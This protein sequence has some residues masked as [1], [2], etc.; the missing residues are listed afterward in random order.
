MMQQ[1]Y[2]VSQPQTPRAVS[3]G[4]SGVGQ[5]FWRA[6]VSQ[7]HPRM[8]FALLLPFFIMLVG[9]ILL[10]I[11]ALSPLTQWIN[12]ML[13]ETSA[14]ITANAWLAS[15]G[16]FSLDAVNT[17]LVGFIVLMMLLPISGIL[18][19]TVAAIFVMPIVVT[20][21]SRQHFPSLVLQGQHAFVVSVW[22][23]VWVSVVFVLGWI[24][25]LPFWLFPPLGLLVSLLWWTFA[26]SRIMRIDAIVE[27][28]TTQERSLLIA[29]HGTGFWTIGMCC[30]LMNL[31]PPAW[32]FLPVFSGLI[33]THYGLDALQRLRAEKTLDI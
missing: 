23:A 24:L 32:I 11:F 1:Q 9:A 29:R 33:Y 12:Q 30:A 3:V 26:F 13:N 15:M 31:V 18:G 16:L 25:T 28:A 10:L 4:L 22:N 17:W 14:L 5:A 7:L 2:S 19:L 27:H 20:H 21:V 8:L 6:L